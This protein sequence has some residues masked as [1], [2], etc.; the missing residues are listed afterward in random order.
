MTITRTSS[1]A[2]LPAGFPF[3]LGAEIEIQAV[4]TRD[5]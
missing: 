3:T 4:A 5:T 2:G 1:G